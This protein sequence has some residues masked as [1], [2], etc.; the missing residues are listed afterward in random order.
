MELKNGSRYRSQVDGTEVIVVKAVPGDVD[1]AVGGHPVVPHGTDATPDLSVKEGFDAG[2]QLGKRYTDASG[3]LELLVTK[4]GTGALSLAG[5]LLELK[6]AKP[7]P[8]SD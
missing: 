1:L 7:L 3:A 5:G 4:P 6:T 8:A 2:T